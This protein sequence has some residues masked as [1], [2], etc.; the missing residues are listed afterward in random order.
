MTAVDLDK[1]EALEKAATPGPWAPD[2]NDPRSI[3]SQD[4]TGRVICKPRDWQDV[5]FLVALRNAFPELLG[6]VRE[7]RGIADAA[8]VYHDP[9]SCYVCSVPSPSDGRAGR[10][11]CELALRL[12]EY[13]A[14]RKAK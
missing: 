4:G 5:D 10:L 13:D 3:F 7:L 11:Q 1:L 14:G 6:E 2:W 9:E 12:A 8:R